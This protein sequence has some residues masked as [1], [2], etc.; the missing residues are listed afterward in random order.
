MDEMLDTNAAFE[1]GP[2]ENAT[3]WS[4]TGERRFVPLA[5]WQ[6]STT[7]IFE[8]DIYRERRETVSQSNEKNK[9]EFPSQRG[10]GLTRQ[11]KD[12]QDWKDFVC[13]VRGQ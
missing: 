9:G 11:G 5:Q 6:V 13:H 3:T 12:R 4:R 2:G 10:K 8:R 7:L 1:E